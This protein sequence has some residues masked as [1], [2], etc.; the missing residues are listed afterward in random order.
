[1]LGRRADFK[2]SYEGK[3]VCHSK[4]ESAL[5]EQM[6]RQSSRSFSAKALANSFWPSDSDGTE[7]TVRTTMKSLRYKLSELECGDVQLDR[8]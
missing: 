2:L 4:R 7:E 3:E 6:M 5:L 8:A 1:M